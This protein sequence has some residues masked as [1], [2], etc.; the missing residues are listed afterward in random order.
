MRGGGGQPNAAAQ[1]HET[2]EKTVRERGFLS[3]MC[4]VVRKIVVKLVK[5]GRQHVGGWFLSSC[6]RLCVASRGTVRR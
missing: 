3:A 5:Y 4:I 2:A 1:S 6:W